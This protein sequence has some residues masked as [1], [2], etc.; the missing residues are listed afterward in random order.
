MRDAVLIFAPADEVFADQLN[1]ALLKHGYTTWARW[2]APF[3]SN[4]TWLEI[5]AAIESADTILVVISPDAI[6]SAIVREAVEYASRE[7]K[8][9]LPIVRRDAN[10]AALNPALQRW[11]CLL[12]RE[13]DDFHAALQR[14]MNAMDADQDYVREHTRLLIRSRVWEINW[15][16]PR[17][18]LTGADLRRAEVWQAR[19]ASHAVRP[20]ER[21]VDYIIASRRAASVAQRR[22]FALVIAAFM[23]TVMLAGFGFKRFLSSQPSINPFFIQTQQADSTSLAVTAP[24]SNGSVDLQAAQTQQPESTLQIPH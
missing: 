10:A 16:K 6:E 14:V 2:E 18:L 22:R 12:F 21:Q 5:Y 13:N 1:A 23:A 3:P 20:I 9:L 19:S 17:G 11:P 8:R 7:Q 4:D 24:G 15:R